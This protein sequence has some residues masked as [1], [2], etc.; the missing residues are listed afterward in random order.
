MNSI[1]ERIIQAMIATI[2]ASA[3]AHTGKAPIRQS[4]LAL[5]REDSPAILIEVVGDNAG[6]RTND[7][8]AR[9]L[10]V[11]ISALWRDDGF[12]DADSAMVDIHR[13]L[14]ANANLGG[15]CQN[16]IQGDAD[17]ENEDA[18]AGAVI[19]PVSYSIPY[20]TRIRDIAVL[21]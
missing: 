1:R 13:E 21:G 2:S 18:D 17:F 4:P 6:E 19:T 12:A 11:R 16:I 7:R 5:T 14:L 15:L 8:E 9:V 10:Q 20:R 3:M